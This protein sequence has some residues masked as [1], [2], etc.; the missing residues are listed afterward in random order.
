MS[1][2]FYLVGGAVRDLLLGD[3]PKDKDYVVVGAT[4]DWMISRGFTQVGASFPVFL[5]QNGDEYALARTERK[6]APGYH[7]FMT[8]FDPT[9]TIEDDLARRDLTINSMA[10]MVDPDTLEPFVLEDNSELV[11]YMIIDPFNGQADL[12]DRILRHTTEAFADDP[13]RVLRLAR[14][15]ARYNFKVAPET[16]EFACKLSAAREYEH[17][18]TERIWTELMKGFGEKYA[19]RMLEVLDETHALTSRPINSFF[20][21]DVSLLVEILKSSIGSKYSPITKAIIGMNRIP[22]MNIKE[23]ASLSIPTNVAPAARY[24]NQHCLMANKPIGPDEALQL[25]DAEHKLSEERRQDALAAAWIR[26]VLISD[27]FFFKN[28][29]TLALVKNGLK[30]LDLKVVADSGPTVGIRERIYAA[31]LEVAKYW[32]DEAQ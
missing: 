26:Q 15:A 31:R 4:P 10:I 17:L 3:N 30:K 11:N 21:G 6:T 13:L 23:I 27:T 32:T 18:S 28:S 29:E 9:I 24:A 12:R 20:E 16:I 7:G 19:Y 8:T 2:T 22:F 1:P 14:F 25:V 5:H